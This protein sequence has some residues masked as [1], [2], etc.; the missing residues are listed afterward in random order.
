MQETEITATLRW[1]DA[2]SSIRHAFIAI[3]RRTG[4]G[5]PFGEWTR[6]VIFAE[7][8]ALVRATFAVGFTHFAWREADSF[9]LTASGIAGLFTTADALWVQRADTRATIGVGCTDFAELIQLAFGGLNSSAGPAA[10]DRR[11]SLGAMFP[12]F[13]P[14][15][16]AITV[17]LARF[18]TGATVPEGCAE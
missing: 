12:L 2:H 14:K 5:T 15:A 1:V 7:L 4:P 16:T 8:T 10:A 9:G 18:E 3:G 13:A 11:A 6:I 17:G